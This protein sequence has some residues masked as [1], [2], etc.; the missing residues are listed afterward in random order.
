MLKRYAP[1]DAQRL[2]GLTILTGALCGIVAVAFHLMIRALERNLIGH[3]RDVDG[4]SR[5]AW[6]LLMPA[7]G[8]AVCG[9]ALHYVAPNA[10]GSG[11]PQVKAV[12]AIEGGRVRFRDAV[13]KFFISALQIGSGSSL[14]R[15]GPTVQICVGISNALG[16]LARVSPQSLRRLVPVGA[17]A[18]I[19]AAFNAPIAA[20]VFT[21]E[22]VVG[23]LD[24]AV[25]SGVVVAA[26]VAAV[27][28]RS[29]LGEHPVFDV[30][31]RYGLDNYS[32]LILYAAL[33]IAAAAVSV[34]FT[35][36]LLTLRARFLRMRR[37]PV[38]V[39]PAIGGLVTGLL[40]VGAAY[41]LQEGGITG[42]GYETLAQALSGGLAVRALLAL[43]AM[44]L[45]ATVF[46]YASGGSGG[47]FAPALFMGAMLGG[48]FGF[49]DMAVL[50]HS[51]DSL[52]AFALVGMGAVFAGSIRA[53]ITSVLIIF[54]MT[55]GYSLILPLMI[56]NMT[57]YAFARRWR[58]TAIYDSLLEQDGVR[59]PHTGRAPRTDA[60]DRKVESAMTRNVVTLPADAPAS[61]A[62]TRIDTLNYDSFPV[63][64]A[65][66][67]VGLVDSVNIRR[68][69]ANGKSDI[70]VREL[71]ESSDAVSPDQ[72]IR[73]AVGHM[74]RNGTFR[75]AVVDPEDR[76]R[77]VGILTLGDVARA[78]VK[79]LPADA[80][81]RT[82]AG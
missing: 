34:L 46:S 58:R 71:I 52:G 78:Q 60:L 20:V 79:E 1:T 66:R 7:A 29:V 72:S 28:E 49:V 81:E 36:S 26:A 53:P 2:L 5:L 22:E 77:L 25:L 57:S 74:S 17:A 4:W 45:A 47:I 38:W 37:V 24:Q 62:L 54:E 6:L 64:D 14:G 35:E 43:C 11:V 44:K 80:L 51:R 19:A 42:G 27:V 75:I 18:G 33:G 41:F 76:T 30:P 21:I 10:R 67:Y 40:A 39:R 50:G 3:A 61:E 16:R 69:T 56:A 68:A 65:G 63:L 15:E 8:A 31:T 12:F 70:R 55:G 82:S 23:D 13:A 9:A 59:L 48:T 73:R 32:S